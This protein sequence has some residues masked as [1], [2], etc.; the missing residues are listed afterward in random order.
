MRRQDVDEPREKPGFECRPIGQFV[1]PDQTHQILSRAED[2]HRRRVEE[3]IDFLN[4]S[5]YRH[6]PAGLLPYGL[7][8]RVDLGR[9]L[10]GDGPGPYTW[11]S[12]RGRGFDTDGGW[13]IDYALVSPGAMPYLR[14]SGIAHDVRGSDHCP[15]WL[16]VDAAGV[17]RDARLAY[18]GVAERTKRAVKA[19]AALE[20]QKLSE[21][22]KDIDGTNARI[23]E[24]LNGH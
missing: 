20:T 4:L 15:V 16:D 8:K 24:A 19:E 5:P 11:W 13:R 21:F 3:I 2:A 14:D 7:Q 12:W 17:V 6:Q 22:Q 10:G 18:G 23:M 1:E 9:A